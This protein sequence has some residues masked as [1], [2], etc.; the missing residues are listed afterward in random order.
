MASGLRKLG[1]LSAVL[2]LIFFA[3]A[4]RISA[5]DWDIRT[6]SPEL[7]ARL[8]ELRAKFPAVNNSQDLHALMQA[9]SQSESLS[10]LEAFLE[11]DR[12]ILQIDVARIVR[13]I[14]VKTLTRAIR[15]DVETKVNRYVG[16]TDSLELRQQMSEEI[17]THLRAKGFY[18]VRV[19]FRPHASPEGISYDL[20]VDE[21]YPC[22]VAR[23]EANFQIPRGVENPFEIGMDCDIADAKRRL[24]ELEA[25]LVSAGYNLQRIQ[26][27]ELI[28]DKDSN[29]ATLKINGSLGKKV[30]YKVDSPIRTPGLISLIFGDSLNTLDPTFT[31]PDAM[32]SELVRH[33]Q[34]QGYD[35]VEVSPPKLQNPDP[36]TIEYQ[37]TVTPGPEY[38]VVD[39]QFEGLNSL[40]REEAV[41]AM[42]LDP[43]IGTSPVFSQD[44]A[45]QARDA[46]L[47]LY[48]QRG[49]WD[50]TV[51]EPRVI[52]NP[53]NGEVKLIYVVREGKK[54]IFQ[55]LFV[56]GA[57]AIPVEELKDLFEVKEG[58]SLA[59]NNLVDFEKA[60]HLKYRQRG[61][62]QV[63]INLE[64]VQNRALRDV[65]TRVVFR[66]QE[67]PR[68]RFGEVFIK[69]TVKTDPHIIR[70][71]VRFKAGETF[72]PDVVEE[73]RQAIADLGLFSSV[74]MTPNDRPEKGSE[75]VI[76]YTIMVREARSGTVSFGPGWSL[77]EGLRFSVESSYNN[78]GGTGRKVFSKGLLNEEKNQESLGGKTLIG[79]YAGVGYFE[80]WLFDLPVDGTLAFN[81]KAEARDNLW[82]ISRSAEAI[83]THRV[84]QLRPKT[85][86]EGFTL[87]KETRE[88]AEGSV[89]DATLI[90]S[91]NLQIRE[92]GLRHIT[93]GRNNLAWPTRGYRIAT[94]FSTA[95][96]LLGGGLR[97]YKWGL[98]FNFYREIIS[99]FVLALG[100][101]YMSF[102][103]VAR[104]DGSDVLP[105]SERLAAGGPENNR[106]FRENSL[107]PA[108][109]STDGRTIYDGGSQRSSHRA[110]IRYQI[111]QEAFA[112]T[113]FLDSS[114]SFFS[115]AEEKR[116]NEEYDRNLTAEGARPQL[117][118]NEPYEF[119]DIVTHPQYLWTKNYVSYGLAANYLTPLG[120]VNLSF[121]WPWR[122]CLNNAETCDNP[123]G[124]R[125]YRQ[126]QGA[127]VSL[128]IGA[129]F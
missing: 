18:R 128:N 82:E 21:D 78:I 110:E 59:W 65:E 35:D 3:F 50:A 11:D 121:G 122:R 88:E 40:S 90:D 111:I 95:T 24:G 85:L 94:E 92:V 29:T 7:Q 17:I 36:E 83:A 91:G 103:N 56:T 109:I 114:N 33:Y 81:H 119:T 107:G 16:Q 14:E 80:P 5:R 49:Y 112:M 67:G 27:P 72:D 41:E 57:K 120:S 37:F 66:I 123:R 99:D 23:I 47:N 125:T 98:G 64:L 31:D 19:Q 43:T 126:L 108:F 12:V 39:V 116:I 70:R 79:R 105:S 73:T 34:Q 52:K 115:R 127:V 113:A 87:Y 89:K 61:F 54:R 102:Q 38:R 15:F 96:Y 104:R 63:Q 48:K 28:Y 26:S 74:S 129:N 32:A 4:T 53:S 77:V 60:V 124:N 13:S 117:E 62:L 8:P 6:T 93:D 22:R 30:R 58:E 55:S 97:Y 118:D 44:T 20:I 101:N 75:E 84:R 1:S 51:F 2:L 76:S 86:I 45:M 46:L 100:F 10:R 68:S 25:E 71:E 9:L 42:D 69:G 106:G